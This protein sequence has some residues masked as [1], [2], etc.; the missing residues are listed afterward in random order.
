MTYDIN[1]IL[2]YT[3]SFQLNADE[4][5]T[6]DDVDD[7]ISSIDFTKVPEFD[8]EAGATKL[9]IIPYTRDYVIKIPFSG[10]YS[11]G[12]Y[13]PFSMAEDN[14]WGDNYC[15]A[16]R[17]LYEEAKE[18]GYAQFFLPLELIN[19]TKY[20]PM[21]IQER[22]DNIVCYMDDEDTKAYSSENSKEIV[23]SNGNFA[24]SLANYWTASCLTSLNED[25]DK[26]Y[27]FIEFLRTTGIMN[28]LHRG[29]LGFKNNKPVIIDYGGYHE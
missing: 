2:N 24:C 27:H 3:M 18:K 12:E 23:R 19:D 8:Y 25:S 28:D 21:Y 16:E 7:F 20:Y 26:M 17:L 15:E 10:R 6:E 1:E 9:V 14:D 4:G 5:F 13:I 11:C 22:A 29:N